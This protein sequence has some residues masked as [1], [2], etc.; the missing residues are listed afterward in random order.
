[1][2]ERRRLI[3]QATLGFGLA[4]P[5]FAAPVRAASGKKADIQNVIAETSRGRVRGINADGIR[6][7][8]GVPYAAP[9]DGPNRFRLAKPAVPWTGV[10]D[11]FAF[12]PM[13]PQNSG[14]RPSFA[15]SWATEQP[16]SE[17]CLV[18]NIWTP[19]LRD[20][21]KRPVMV[22]FHGGGFA[23]GSG[24]NPVY[25]GTNLA[26]KGD[27]VVV[28]LNHRLNVF[29]HLYLARSGGAEYAE[30]GNL[31]LLDL[32]AALHWIHTNI[33]EFGGD[34]AN[35]T[36]FGQSGGGAKVSM[37]MAMP[38]TRGL[39]HRAI[40]QSGSRLDGLTADEAN[41]NAL[42]FLKAADVPVTD[43]SRLQK[44]PFDQ[45]LAI[46]RK[47]MASG[48]QVNFSPVVDGRFLPKAPWL[49]DAP[50]SSATVPMMIGTTRTE[51]TALI[52]A[53]DPS[54]FSLD[55]AGLRKKLSTWLPANDIDRVVAGYRKA[56]LG[57]TPSDLF[58]AITTARRVRQ[59]AWAQAERKAAQNGAAVWLY[60]LDWATPVD[61]G[62]WKSPH[63]L[64]LAFVFDNVARSESMVGRGGDQRALADQ[65][66]AAWLAFAHAGNPNNKASPQ[67][68]PF[69]VPER[70]TMVFDAKPRVENDFR[71]DERQLLASLPLVRVSV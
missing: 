16:M 30:S 44:L 11:T 38:Q 25:D 46:L 59:Q 24:A 14:P 2:L 31:G 15:A 53:S 54:A 26:R 63:S 4:G 41:A 43:L 47:V 6:I 23:N 21:H 1:V 45:L 69:R 5:V 50:A 29:G 68:P 32:V 51:T 3:G 39:F 35:V 40:V 9:T 19:A 48:S 55:E 60:E 22:W 28:T 65:M 17:D 33:A 36:I 18:L 61:D 71:G 27:V 20:H 58:F 10:R 42:T 64:D 13:C 52:G 62:K 49:P 37:L 67:W 7:F 12:G 66:S 34:P 8:K 56:A 70:A 57:A